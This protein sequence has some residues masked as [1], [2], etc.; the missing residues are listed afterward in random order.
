MPSIKILILSTYPEK[1]YAVRCLRNGAAGYLTKE[2]APEELI[3]A[4]RKVAIGRKFLSSELAEILAA[5]LDSDPFKMP[6]ELLSDREFEVLCLIGRGKTVSQIADILSLS[7]PT[8]N[9]YRARI[10][11]KMNMQTTAQL[12][13]YVL[14]NKLVDRVD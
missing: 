13:H 14:E 6:H 11:E 4:I 10:L 5:H 7:L 8:I 12:M 1:Q 9:T 3:T 2:R